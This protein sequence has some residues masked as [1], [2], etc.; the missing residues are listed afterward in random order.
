MNTTYRCADDVLGELE[1][2]YAEHVA[3]VWAVAMVDNPLPGG[4]NQILLTF[5]PT[6]VQVTQINELSARFVRWARV[7]GA[8]LERIGAG[9]PKAFLEGAGGL[10]TWFRFQ[11]SAQGEKIPH[12][13]W[14]RVYLG[15]SSRLVAALAEIVSANADEFASSA[16][17]SVPFTDLDISMQRAGEEYVVQATSDLGTAT[18]TFTPPRDFK[19]VENFVLRYCVAGGAVRRVVPASVSPFS[20]FGKELFDGLFRD[21]VK[22]L[23]TAVREETTER[24]GGLRI[25]LRQGNAPELARI[26]WEFLFD[27]A[28]FICLEPHLTLVRHLDTRRA[29]PPLPVELPLRILITISAPPD[30]PELEVEAEATLVRLALGPYIEMGLVELAITPDGR[31]STLQRM[32]ASGRRA[33]RPWHIWHFIGHGEFD[34]EASTGS[35]AFEADFERRL[36]SGFEMATLLRDYSALRLVVMNACETAASD[37]VDAMS[38]VAGAIVEGGVSSVVAMQFPVSDEAAI[39]FV[40][41]FYS[42]LADGTAVDE[43]VTE[44]RRAIFFQPNY[45]E[46]ATPVVFTRQAGTE[47]FKIL[48]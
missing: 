6:S 30:M 43:A 45:G 48:E 11:R 21:G 16:V 9:Y 18:S 27:G 29:A 25:R 19:D 17:Q 4:G 3:L 13:D 37:D 24:R 33:G 32:L 47:V 35:L 42:C 38:S 46:W 20:Q 2:M 36:V 39:A 12:D 40:G 22:E 5:E 15:E 31:L 7:V 28:G 23:Y 41:Q 10:E 8:Y 14:R 44:A 1:Q 34:Q 26:P